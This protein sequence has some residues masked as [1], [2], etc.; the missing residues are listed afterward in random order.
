MTSKTKFFG[1]AAAAI[2]LS[3][4]TISAAPAH[5]LSIA[6]G[7]EIN[8]NSPVRGRVTIGIDK[9]NFTPDSASQKIQVTS[10][11]GSFDQVVG[12][13]ET[14]LRLGLSN[15]STKILDLVLS[16]G[17][18][19]GP[20]IPDFISG[21]K[22]GRPVGNLRNLSFDLTSAT[23]VTPG[24]LANFVGLFRSD[25]T[26]LSRASGDLT[27]QGFGKNGVGTSYSLTLAAEPIPTPALLP[28]LIGLG[29]GVLRKRKKEMAEA[30][31]EA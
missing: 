10:G 15:A 13:S 8:F 2:A 25:N 31:A 3:A 17:V 11:S 16:G 20:T 22:I 21:I 9:I 12:P 19:S 24:K 28:G 30:T 18:Y 7:S 4:A 1:A 27:S 14:V 6:P 5:A 29:M 23:V 26:I